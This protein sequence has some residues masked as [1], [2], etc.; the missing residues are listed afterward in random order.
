MKEPRIEQLL[1]YAFVLVVVAYVL[2]QARKPDR[3]AG[4][5]LVSLMNVSHSGMTDWGLTHARIEKSFAI[6]DVGCGGGR[7]IEKLAASATDGVVCGVDYADGSVAA[8]RAKNARS[9]EAGRVEIR[10]ASV[11]RL[12]YPDGKFDV[13]SAVETQ[14]YWPNPASDMKEIL[15]V[16]KPG[17]TLIVIAESFKGGRFDAL[18]WPVMWLLRSTH[19]SVDDQRALFMKAGYTDVEIVTEPS[20]GW[21]C[22][23]GRKPL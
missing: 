3:W 18:Q 6:L 19:L 7:T 14:Y 16:L 9:I 11:S 8:A 21:I 20:K 1:Y 13:V 5:L 22:A 12:P 10:K 15:R 4:R 23:T 2:N 17:G